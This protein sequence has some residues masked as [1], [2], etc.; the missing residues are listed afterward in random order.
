MMPMG[1]FESFTNT[2]SLRFKKKEI[3]QS[4]QA[5]QEDNVRGFGRSKKIILA[6]VTILNLTLGYSAY[7]HYL[8]KELDKTWAVI[9]TLLVGDCGMALEFIIHCFPGLRYLRCICITS[10]CYFSSIYYAVHTL[11]VPGM[12]PG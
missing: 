9:Y 5:V 7:V 6:A 8:R 12:H 1:G 3:E 2:C 10:G 4:F 11:P